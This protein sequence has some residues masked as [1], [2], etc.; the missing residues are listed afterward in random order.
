MSCR[1]E[2][3]CSA[4]FNH[5]RLSHRTRGLMPRRCAGNGRGLTNEQKLSFKQFAECQG[6]KAFSNDTSN[7]HNVNKETIVVELQTFTFDG[8]VTTTHPRQRRLWCAILY[9]NDSIMASI[10][11]RH[12]LVPSKQDSTSVTASR[13]LPDPYCYLDISECTRSHQAHSWIQTGLPHR[14]SRHH[15]RPN[16]KKVSLVSHHIRPLRRTCCT[17]RPTQQ[18]LKACILHHSTQTCPLWPQHRTKRSAWR[19][20]IHSFHLQAQRHNSI[21]PSLTQKPLPCQGKHSRPSQ[22]EHRLY[23]GDRSMRRN[24]LVKSA[25]RCLR[26][27]RI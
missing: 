4:C 14:Q 1:F 12:R 7:L 2:R 16:L 19:P 23:Q 24:T 26:V 3:N 10:T 5:A 25:I 13:G 20:R 27:R 22:L 18:L 21:P 6:T 11:A 8:F 15:S 9:T 17:C